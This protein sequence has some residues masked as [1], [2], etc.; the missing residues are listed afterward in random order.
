[1]SEDKQYTLTEA[2]QEFAKRTNHRVWELLEKPTRTA[3]EEKELVITA[4]ASLYHWTQAGGAVE[5]QRGH[6]LLSRVYVVLGRVQDALAQALKCSSITE[7][8]PDEMVD[9]D[10]AYAREALARSYAL[11]GDFKQADEHLKAAE[12]L[13]QAI[14]DAKDQE[15]FLG[16]LNSG[17]WYGIK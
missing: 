1:M 7:S 17:D 3:E 16:D 14:K 6:W 9:F 4:N 15:I 5:S 2:H 12:I 13:G 10:L 8:N 11:A